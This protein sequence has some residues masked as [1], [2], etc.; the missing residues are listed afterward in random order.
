MRK[1]FITA[2]VFCALMLLTAVFFLIAGID[3]YRTE[4]EQSPNESFAGMGAA[5]LAV[6]GIFF[7][8]CELNLFVTVYYF[9]F[10]RKTTART[11][12]SILSTLTLVL[13]GV[14]EPV[15]GVCTV[16][17]RYEAIFCGLLVA[18]VLLR[19]IYWVVWAVTDNP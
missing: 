6:I 7:L 12:L 1:K 17:R 4:M 10:F 16:L 11:V 13:I 3:V 14:Y 5:I 8:I 2:S 19:S 18:Y 15:S 9:L